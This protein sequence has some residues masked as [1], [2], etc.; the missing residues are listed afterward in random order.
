MAAALT[1]TPPWTLRL[2]SRYVEARDLLGRLP[3]SVILLGLRLAVGFVF[4]NS[5][6]LK[7]R[8]FEFAVKLFEQEYRLPF[9][10]PVLATQLA[11]AVEVTVPIFLFLGLATRLATLP[12]LGMVAVI[13]L[14]VY[15]QAWTEHLLWASAL[16]LLLTR[17]PGLLSLDHLIERRLASRE[18]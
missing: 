17:G 14:L 2:R 18:A 13:Q 7:L 10:D 6:M 15:P 8:S 11:L 9:I 16:V 5:G 3:M 1:E 12:L 4:F